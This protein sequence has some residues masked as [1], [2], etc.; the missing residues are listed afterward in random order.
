MD[1]EP[2]MTGTVFSGCRITEKL[3]QGGMGT[4][5]KARHEALDKFVCVKLLSPELAK[6]Q[7]NVEF[8]LREARSAG[9][10]EHPN[11]VHIYNFG[12]ENGAYFIIMSYVEGKSLQDLVAEKG[13]L[14]V[15]EDTDILTGILDGL[16]HAHSKTVIHRDI[17]PANILVDNSGIPHIVDFGLARSISE[18]KQLTMAGEMIGTA[19]FMS[20]E[21]GLAGTVDSRADLYS[22]GATYYYIL[23]GKYPF[24]G[25][26]SIEVIHKHIGEPVPNIILVNPDI[27][28]WA[29]RVIER[30]MRKKP[31][32]RFQKAE[33]VAAELRKY[34]SGEVPLEAVSA[35]RTFDIPE[36][37]AR[38]AYGAPPPPPPPPP[39]QQP[40][41]LDRANP[42]TSDRAQRSADASGAPK[43]PEPPSMFKEPAARPT[44]QLA[45]LHNSVKIALHLA[46]TLGATGCFILA[47]ASGNIPGSLSAPLASNPAAAFGLAGIGVALSVW[48]LWQKP[49]KFTPVYVLF[50]MAA[51]AA[52]YAG[53]AYIPAP[54][55]A[56]TV[57]KGFLAL[58]IGLESMFSQAN[59]IVYALFFYLAASKAVF[60]DNWI[61][62]VLAVA[63]YLLG[64]AF[65][66]AY[67]KAGAAIAPEGVWL[68]VG[69]GLALA[70]LAAALTQKSFNLLFSPQVFF[71]AAN[72]A[73]FAM[74]TNPQVESITGVKVRADALAAAQANQI[75][76]A[77]Y[78]RELEAAQSEVLYDV[79][80]RPVE[81]RQ[82]AAPAEI[83]PAS[84]GKLRIQAR[85]QYY[86]ALGLR[87]RSA[88]AESAGII[89]I[90]LFLALMANVC[91][92]EELLAAYRER[93]LY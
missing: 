60:R 56:D 61:I 37:T 54:A 63:A 82:P 22:V 73:M 32:E 17:K 28:L 50:A 39:A 65:T 41:S 87:I 78:Q 90:A 43:P 27:P 44:L 33:E 80:G 5:Y 11:I 91:F 53:G 20:P 64:L 92:I 18:E 72:V 58:K 36:V 86:S 83:K 52:A 13:C 31:E 74:F 8:F 70:G 69:G 7:R 34:N 93:E 51:A 12:Q 15:K 81:K 88:L 4:V 1:T 62:K 24:D 66:Y 10:L 76:R 6:E 29:A 46:L 35:E 77:N 89:F 71:L 26:S 3:G 68:A 42:R 84:E 25:K 23:T 48:A 14:P 55:G 49:L 19:Y 57:S 47:G 9:K 67:F 75:S 21:Q 38:M 40:A 16:A 59:L 45:A 30:L 79:D 2:N 85:M